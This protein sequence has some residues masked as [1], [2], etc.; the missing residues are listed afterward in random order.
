LAPFE[1][2]ARAFTRRMRSD[3]AP[4]FQAFADRLGALLADGGDLR[5]R[6]FG[7]G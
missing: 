1:R 4:V 3:H 7:D 6:S 2:I 5:I